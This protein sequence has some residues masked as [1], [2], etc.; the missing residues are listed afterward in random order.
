MKI[1]ILM[2]SDLSSV[3]PAISLH[4]I[5]IGASNRY[6]ATTNSNLC[7]VFVQDCV[8]SFGHEWDFSY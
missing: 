1:I 5:V 3:W 7:F 8:H 4:A 6:N 2:I